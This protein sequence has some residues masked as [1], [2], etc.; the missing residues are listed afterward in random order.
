MMA[1][2][3]QAQELSSSWS[4]EGDQGRYILMVCLLPK[5]IELRMKSIYF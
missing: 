4:E 2:N 3:D 5:T 1:L